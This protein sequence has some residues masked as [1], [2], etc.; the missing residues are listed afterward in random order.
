M[1][2]AFVA[3]KDVVYFVLKISLAKSQQ[4]R[5]TPDGAEKVPAVE[6]GFRG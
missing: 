3:L 6:F 5:N 4:A 1:S 2:Q